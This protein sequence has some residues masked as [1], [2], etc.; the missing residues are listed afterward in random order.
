MFDKLKAGQPKLNRDAKKGEDQGYT[1]KQAQK[2]K[3]KHAVELAAFWLTIVKCIVKTTKYFVITIFLLTIIGQLIVTIPCCSW[4]LDL[5]P[6]KE[7]CST[8]LK[9]TVGF[10]LSNALNQVGKL[11]TA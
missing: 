5:N 9:V 1:E 6:W 8:I 2:H 7:W 11:Q 10:L 4:D 3:N